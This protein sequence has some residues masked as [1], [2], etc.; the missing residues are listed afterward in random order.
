MHDKNG[1]E[2]TSICFIILLKPSFSF[3][4]RKRAIAVPVA[5]KVAKTFFCAIAPNSGS[6]RENDLNNI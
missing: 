1:M 3:T 5:R 4:N 6:K 2:K